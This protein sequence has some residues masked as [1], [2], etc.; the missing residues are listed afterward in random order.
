MIKSIPFADI[1]RSSRAA[2]TDD[3]KNLVLNLLSSSGIAVNGH[4]PWDIK[5]RNAVE[6]IFDDIVS[7]SM[8]EHVGY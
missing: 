8:F 1:K 7:L 6:G 4:Q 2:A 5:V 3:E